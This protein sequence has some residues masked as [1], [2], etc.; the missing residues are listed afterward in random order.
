M[1]KSNNEQLSALIDGEHENEHI[2]DN[3]IHNQDMKNIW[4]RYHLIG[5]CL[6]DNL[7]EKISNQ[8]SIQVTN[9]LRDEPTILAPK[10]TKRFNTKPLVGFAIAASVAMVAVFSIK[11]GNEQ[12]SSFESAPTIAATTVAQPQVYSFPVPQVLPAAIKRSD[13]LDSVASQ[14]LNNY[15]I[16]HNEY[17]SSGRV[18]AILPYVR[19]V[20][21]EPL[22]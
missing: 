2:L 18:N 21:T 3:L 16:N 11:S 15:L 6:R 8:V 9:A 7:P 20:T 10:I 22:E 1:N 12:D 4:S 19:I 13:T 14:R 17:R 5:D